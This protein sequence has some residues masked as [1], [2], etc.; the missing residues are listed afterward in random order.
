MKGEVAEA[1]AD[2]RQAGVLGQAAEALGRLVDRGA[3]RLNALVQR[4]ERAGGLP[5]VT[6]DDDPEAGGAATGQSRAPVRWG[7]S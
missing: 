1:A 2:R 4:V 3:D 6:R 7:S 5:V